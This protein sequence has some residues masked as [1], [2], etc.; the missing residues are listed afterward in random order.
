MCA[1][2]LF[3][4][5]FIYFLM[6]FLH[7]IWF[8][9]SH[10]QFFSPNDSYIFF[11]LRMINLF[12]HNFYTIHFF[13]F[14]ETWFMYF[15]IWFF[16]ASFM[17]MFFFTIHLFFTFKWFIF[18]FIFYTQIYFHIFFPRLIL[19]CV[20]PTGFIDF[21]FY[22]CNHIFMTKCVFIYFS[23]AIKYQS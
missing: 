1:F 13:L 22:R 11:F 19:S 20:L 9:Y 6:G 8:T 7:T 12:P 21:Y 17:F 4:L 23:H 16:D 14:F 5:W 2:V 18:H 15:H 10:M 3:C